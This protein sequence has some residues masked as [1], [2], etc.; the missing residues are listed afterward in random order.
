MPEIRLTSESIEL[1]DSPEA[2][3]AYFSAQQWSD[4]LP[5]IPPTEDRV[6]AMLGAAGR[7]PQ[8][9]LGDMPPGWGQAT[10]EKLPSTRSWPAACRPTSRW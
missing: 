5:V 3:D 6:R 1:D 7:D 2:V 10:V 9:S 4:G 8:D